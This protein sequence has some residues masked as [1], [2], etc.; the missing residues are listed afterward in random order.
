MAT[1][2]GCLEGVV[3]EWDGFEAIRD[4][5]R[6]RHKILLPLPSQPDQSKCKV[7][8]ATGGFNYEALYPLAKRLQFPEGCVGMHSLPAIFRQTLNFFWGNG[9]GID[10][11]YHI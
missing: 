4:R 10:L 3:Q 7:D 11:W 1:F 5:M 9:F 8:V 6:E 2:N